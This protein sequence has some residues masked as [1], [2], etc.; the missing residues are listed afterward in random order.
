[1]TGKNDCII[2]NI[3]FHGILEFL[4]IVCPLVFAALI[5][6]NL[7]LY[8]WLKL[9]ELSCDS[10]QWKRWQ[11][12]AF[13]LLPLTPFPRSVRVI[14][15]TWRERRNSYGTL[16]NI[17]TGEYLC[18]FIIFIFRMIIV[19]VKNPN[20]SSCIYFFLTDTIRNS[21]DWNWIFW[22]S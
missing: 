17:Y 20:N 3:F 8:W 6:T 19:L 21:G 11:P 2:H 4:S 15:Q 9:V 14:I 22:L 16:N 12:A 1:M 7:N 13:S 5:K 10:F 18:L